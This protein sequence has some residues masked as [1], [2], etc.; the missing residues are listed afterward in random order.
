MADSPGETS[1]HV[2][3]K[4][5]G[6]EVQVPTWRLKDLSEAALEALRRMFT[7]NPAPAITE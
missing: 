2:T 1:D 4:F 3:L 6:E 7:P 5:E